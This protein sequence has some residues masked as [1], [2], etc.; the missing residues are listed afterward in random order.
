MF[1]EKIWGRGWHLTIGSLI[2][3]ISPSP[4]PTI[5]D[6]MVGVHKEALCF[7][8]RPQH[9]YQVLQIPFPLVQVKYSTHQLIATLSI[10]RSVLSILSD[11]V[12]QRITTT[13]GIFWF[14][15]EYH[16]EEKSHG[17]SERRSSFCSNYG[18]HSGQMEG[19]LIQEVYP[20]HS[21]QGHNVWHHV[22]Y[23]SPYSTS[24]LS[25]SGSVDA[26]TL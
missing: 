2:G 19:M 14:Q 6:T 1:S 24:Q 25:R 13:S 23:T 11:P 15:W 4:S 17:K 26:Y 21:L 7:L 16:T 12:P 10:S 22:V 18:H 20:R 9:N 3:L 5:R 8:S